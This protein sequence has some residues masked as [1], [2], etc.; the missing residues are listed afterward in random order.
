MVA[1]VSGSGLGLF[2]TTGSSGNPNVGRGGE[3]VSVNTATGNLIIQGVDETLGARGLDLALVRTY[4]SQ[5]LLN[6]DNGDNWRLGVN[7]RVFALTGTVN[8]AG[9]TITKVFGDAAQVVYTYDTTLG[10]YVSTD[11]DGA[12]DTL[13]FNATTSEWT[14]TDESS[15][16][17][18]TYDS[19]GRL[20]ASRDS[21]GNLVSYIYTG[22]LLTQIVDASGQQ[23]F[24]DYTGNNLTQVRVVSSGAT[25]TL[26]HYSYDGQNRLSTVTVDLSPGDNAIADGDVYVTTYTYEGTS[27]RVASVTQ[28]DGSSC[29]FT[30]QLIDGEYRVHTYTDGEGRVTTLEYSQPVGGG[31]STP[32]SA[33]ANSAVLS[34][35]ESSTSSTD[36][37]I[38]NGALVTNDTQ[39]T[40]DT[41]NLNAGALSTPAGGSVWSLPTGFDMPPDMQ[42]SDPKVAF[43]ANGNGFVVWSHIFADGSGELLVQRYTRATNSWGA[44]ETLVTNSELTD[45]PIPS[46]LAVDAAGNA[47]V[48]F[49]A[50]SNFGAGMVARRYDAASATWGMFGNLGGGSSLGTGYGV[51][52]VAINGAFAAVTYLT[53]GGGHANLVTSVLSGS[54][55]LLPVAMESSTTNVDN[56]SMAMD[57]QGNINVVF[58]QGTAVS[59]TRY[60]ASTATWSS[61]TTL[62]AVASARVQV[63]LDGA[64]NGFATWAQGADLMMSRYTRST[65]TWGAA[66]ALDSLSTTVGTQALAM[67]AAGNAVVSWTQSDG[68]AASVYARRYNAATSAWSAATALES[69]AGPAFNNLSVAINGNYAAVEWTLQHGVNYTAYGATFNGTAWSA[70]V[71]F[72]AAGPFG[73]LSI[74]VDSLGNS[75]AFWQVGDGSS[76]IYYSRF[77]NSLPA[78][79]AWN[80]ASLIEAEPSG[81]TATVPQVAYDSNGNGFAIWVVKRNSPAAVTIKAARY[82]RSTNTWAAP[83]TLYTAANA[84]VPSASLAVDAGGNAIVAWTVGG[85]MSAVR[86]TGTTWG[87]VLSAG[88]GSGAPIVAMNGNFAAIVWQDGSPLS[89]RAQWATR[90]NG[91]AWTAKVSLDLAGVPPFG[92]TVAVDNQGNI[93]V[94]FAQLNSG[95]SANGL[96]VVRYTASSNTWSAMLAIATANTSAPAPGNPQIAFDA[97]GNGVLAWSEGG[98]LRTARYTRSTNTWAAAV[99][100]DNLSG[101]VSSPSLSLDAAGN[102]LVAWIQVDETDGVASAYSKIYNAATATW[103]AVTLHETQSL[104]VTDSSLRTAINGSFASVGWLQTDGARD[105]LYTARYNGSAWSAAALAEANINTVATPSLALDSLGNANLFWQQSDGTTVS[106]YQS[107][108]NVGGVPSYTVPPGATWPSVAFDLYGVNSAAAGTALQT[109]MGNPAL[110]SGAQISG[111]PATL[112]VTTVLPVPPYFL[113]PGTPTTPTWRSIAAVVYGVD[114]PEAGAALQALMGSAYPT[115]SVGLHISNLPALLTVQTTTTTTVPAYYVVTSTDWADV[116]EAVYGTRDPAAVEALKLATGLT[117]L[118]VGQHLPVPLTLNYTVNG[119]SG[120]TSSIYLRTDIEDPLGFVATQERDAAGRLTRVQSATVGD[121]RPETTFA[122]NADGNVTSITENPAGLNRQTVMSYDVHGN[123]LS[124]RDATG[125]TI[126]RTYSTR[127]QLLTESRYL[128]AD[129]DGAGTGVATAPITSRF[130]YDAEDHLRFTVSASGRVVE[131]RYNAAGERTTSLQYGGGL[132]ALAGLASDAALTEAQLVSWAQGQNLTTLQR[133]DFTYDFRGSLATTTAYTATDAAGAGAGTASVTRFVYDQRGRLLSSIDARGELTAGIADDYLTSYTYDGLGR[134]LAVTEWVSGATQVTT[135]SSYDDANRRDTITLAN[136]LVTTSVYNSAGE[137]TS[138]ILGASGVL[139]TTNYRYDADGRLRM[140]TD[141]LG[142]RTFSFYDE[143][144]R[145]VAM[146]DAAGSLTE[147]IYDDVSALV[148]SVQYAVQLDAATLASLVDGGVPQDV[149]LADLRDAADGVP[150]S[151]RITRSV[152]DVAGRLAFGID[153]DGAVTRYFYDGAGRRTTEVRFANRVAID[154]AVESLSVDFVEP[155]IVGSPED[156]RTRHFYDAD[157]N[158]IAT[159][160]SAGYLSEYL[161]DPAGFLVQQVGYATRTAAQYWVAGTLEELRPAQSVDDIR[162]RLF[163]DAQGRQV[164]ALDSQGYLS[165]SVYDVAGNMVATTRYDVV[166]PYTEGTSTFASLRAT[167]LAAPGA[168]ARTLTNA[169]DGR[170]RITTSTDFEGVVSTFAYDAV[171]NLLRSTRAVATTEAR[172]AEMRYD[173]LGR[174]VQQL[175]A[176]GSALITSGMSQAA[177]DDIWSRYGVSVAYDAAGRRISTTVRPNDAQTNTTLYF[178]DADGRQRFEVNAPGEV[179]ETRYD[180][181][182]QATESLAYVN[183]ISTASLAG[184]AIVQ[185]L[186]DRVAAAADAARDSHSL[187]AYTR[188]GQVLSTATSE[189]ANTAYEYDAFGDNTARTSRVNDGFFRNIMSQP[190]PRSLRYDYTYDTR[191]QLTRTAYDVDGMELEW[192]TGFDPFHTVIEETV[193]DAFGRIVSQTDGRGSVTQHSYDRLGREVTTTDAF[194]NAG[195]TSYDAFSR[196]LTM[197]DRLGNQTTYAYDDAARSMSMTTPEGI[198][199]VTTHNRHGQTL[200][201]TAAGKTT[202]YSYDLNGALLESFDNLGSLGE[203]SYDRAGR[204]ITT[205]TALGTTTTFGYDAADRVLTRQVDSPLD[206][207]SLVSQYVYDGQGRITR[208]TEPGGRVTATTYDRDSRVVQVAVDPDGLNLRTTYSYDRAGNVIDVVEGA[209]SAL[210]RHVSYEYD[211]LGRRVT[212]RIDPAINS[213]DNLN[214]RT[215]YRYDETGNLIRKSNSIG[216]TWFAYDAGSRLRF[217]IDELGGVSENVFD[218]VGRVTATRRYANAIDTNAVATG[219][220]FAL[221]LEGVAAAL[222]PSGQDRI[223]QS[224]FDGDGREV[225]TINGL[226]GVTERTFD[227]N[228]NVTRTRLYAKAI[229]TATYHSLTE[230]RAALTLAGNDIVNVAAADRVSFAA[231][232]LRGRATFA[233]NGLGAVTRSEYDVRGNVVSSTAYATPR[234]VSLPN[235]PAALQSWAAGTAVANDPHNRSTRYWYDGLDRLRFTLDAEGYLTETRFDDIGRTEESVSYAGAP[236]AIGAAADLDDVETIAVGLRNV[237]A[238]HYSRSVR[239][240]AGRVT[241]VYDAANNY[242]EYVYDAL[243][244]RT[245]L[246]NKLGAVWTYEYDANRRMIAE[247]TPL[248]E[249]TRTSVTDPWAVMG[250]PLATTVG[251]RSVI[252]RFEY[253]ELGNLTLRIEDADQPGARYTQYWYDR[254]GRQERVVIFVP[255]YDAEGESI[256]DWYGE[257]EARPRIEFDFSQTT[258]TNYDTLGDAVFN[259]DAAGSVTQNIYDRLGRLRYAVDAENGVTEYRYD[260]FGNQTELVRYAESVYLDTEIA[261]QFTIDNIASFITPDATRDRVITTEYDRVNRAVRVIEPATFVFDPSAGTPGGQYYTAS[262]TTTNQYDAFGRL[263]KQSKLVNPALG[264]WADTYSYYDERGMCIASIDALGYLTTMEYDAFGNALRTVEYAKALAA[265]TWNTSTH[266]SA[267]VT[268][269]AS[270]PH[271]SAGYDRITEWTYDSRNRRVSERHRGIEYSAATSSGITE[272]VTDLLM[273]FGFDALG[274]QTRVTDGNGAATYTYYDVLGRQIAIAAPSRDA[275][276]GTILT[277][278]VGMKRDAFGNMVEQRVYANGASAAS[279]AAFTASTSASDRVSRTLYD[280]RNL[281]IQN[282]DAEGN[283]SLVSYNARGDIGREWQATGAFPHNEIGSA[284]VRITAYTYDRLGRQT[285]AVT[286]LEADRDSGAANYRYDEISTSN[287]YNNFGEIEYRSGAGRQET[288]EYD[289]SGRVVRSNSGD[290]VTKVYLYD[291][292]GH[293]TAEI[294]SSTRDL[295]QLDIAAVAALT[296]GRMRTET[297]YDI[298]GRVVEQRQ[299]NFAVANPNVGLQAIGGLLRVDANVMAPNNPDAVFRVVTETVDYGDGDFNDYETSQIDPGASLADGGGYMYTAPTAEN[300]GGGWVQDPNYALVSKRYI[301][302]VR[303]PGLGYDNGQRALASFEFRPSS[304]GAYTPLRVVNLPNNEIGV[305]ISALANGSYEYRLTYTMPNATEPYAIATG[306]LGVGGVLSLADTTAA[307]LAGENLSATSV[308]TEVALNIPFRDANFRI[309]DF[310]GIAALDSLVYRR[311]DNDGVFEYV[312]DRAAEVED[313]GGYYRTATGFVQ[314]PDYLPSHSRLVQWNAAADPDLTPVFEFSRVGSGSW[315][316]LAVESLVGGVYSVAIGDYADGDYEFRVS[317]MSIADPSAA[318]LATATGAIR[319]E[320]AQVTDSVQLVNDRPDDAGTVAPLAIRPAGSTNVTS[321]VVTSAEFDEASATGVSFVGTNDV[322]VTFASITGPV[323]IELEY[324]TVAV[325]ALLDPGPA[326]EGW[327]SE[328]RRISLLVA[329]GSTAASGLHLTWSDVFGESSSGGISE[330]LAVRV[331]AVSGSDATLRYSTNAVDLVDQGGSTLAWKA[332]WNPAVTATFNVRRVGSDEWQSIDVTRVAGDFVVDL[333]NLAPGQWEYQAAQLQDGDVRAIASGVLTTHGSSVLN[334]QEPPPGGV[335]PIEAV[336]PVTGYSSGAVGITLTS[337]ASHAIAGPAV[338]GQP[339]PLQWNG[340]NQ[341]DLTWADLGTGDVRVVIDYTSADR[342]SYNHVSGGSGWETTAA[343][344]PGTRASREQV[345]TTGATGAAFTWTDSNT[346]LVGGITELQRVRV[347]TLVSGSWVLRLDHDPSAVRSGQSIYWGKADDP[348]VTSEFRVRAVG[349]TTWA[350][351]AITTNG[352][353][354]DIV[355]VDNLAAGN[356]EYQILRSRAGNVVIALTSG[357]FTI[358]GNREAGDLA[359]T[360]H[361]VTFDQGASDFGPVTWNGNDLAWSQAPVAGDTITLR[362]RE[363]GSSTWN[364]Q[365]ISGSGPDFSA[366]VGATGAT[367]VEYEVLYTHSGQSTPYSRAGGRLNA[368][369]ATNYTP[370]TYTFT[371]TSDYDSVMA[372]VEGILAYDG[373]ISFTTLIL[374]TDVEFRVRQG[375]GEW[376][377]LNAEYLGDGYSVDLHSLL[378][379]EYSYEI[380]YIHWS[381]SVPHAYASGTVTIGGDAQG[382]GMSLLDTT[383]YM[384]TIFTDSSPG[385]P[386]RVQTFDRWG[387]VVSA[388]DASGNTTNYRYNHTNTLLETILP[389]VQVVDIA[390]GT[391]ETHLERPVQENHYDLLGRL[392]ATRDANGNVSRA[393]YNVAGDLLR[394]VAADGGVKSRVYNAFGDVVLS[395]DQLG[396]RTRLAYDRLSQLTS[397]EREVVLGGLGSGNTAQ[398]LIDTYA[399]DDLGE[400][401]RETNAAGESTEYEYF[402]DGRLRSRTTNRGFTTSYGYDAN[403]NKTF[404]RDANGSTQRWDY[405]GFNRMT[406]SEDM[407][408]TRT[409]YRYDL[410]GQLTYQ[411]SSLGQRQAYFYDEAGHLTRIVDTGSPSKTLAPVVGVN[412]ISE[413]GYDIEGRRV[414]ERTVI[415][416]RVHQDNFTSFDAL[417]RMSRAADPDYE[418]TYSYDA[419]GNRTRINADYYN[420]IG[421]GAGYVQTQDLWYTYD[422]MN[423]VLTSQ[424]TNFAGT[425]SI[426]GSQGIDLTYNLKGER[427]SARTN[428]EHYG[429]SLSVLNGNVVSATYNR[430]KFGLFTERYTY[431]GVGRLLATD[432]DAPSTTHNLGTGAVTTGVTPLRTAT[433]QFDAASREILSVTYSMDPDEDTDTSLDTWTTNTTYDGDGR[434]AQQVTRLN[435]IMN[436]RVTFGD[437]TFYRS[438]TFTVTNSFFRAVVAR[439]SGTTGVSSRTSH[440]LPSFSSSVRTVQNVWDGQGWDSAGNLMGYRVEFFKETNGKL[441]YYTDHTFDYRLAQTYQLINEKTNSEGKG[442]PGKGSTTRTYNVNGELVQYSDNKDQKKNRYFAND[443]QGQAL[444]VVNGKF[445]GRSGRLSA[446]RAFDNALTRT[447][448]KV[449][450]QYFFFANGQNIGTFG[451]LVDSEGTIKANFD[452]NYTPVSGGYPSA[453]PSEVVAHS[454]DTLRT[455]AARV[456]GDSNLWYVLAEANGLTN[457]D[458]K[459]EA[460]VQ[461]QVPNKVL[462]LSNNAESFKPY[463]ASLALGDTTPTQ[464]PPGGGCGVIGMIIM[465]VVMIVATIFTAG[466]AAVGF[467]A[468]FGQIMAAGASVMLGGTAVAGVAVAASQ[469]TLGFAGTA[470]VAAGVGSAVSQGVGI[471]IGAQQKFDWKQVGISAISA[472]VTAGFGATLNAGGKLANAVNVV[473]AGGKISAGTRVLAAAG[474]FLANPVGNAIGSSMLTQGLSVATG[475]QSSFNWREVAVAAASSIGSMGASKAGG[476]VTGTSGNAVRGFLGKVTTNAI[477]K[478]IQMAFAGK[479]EVGAVLADAFGNAVGD[480]IVE[481]LQ[482]GATPSP[483]KPAVVNDPDFVEITVQKNVANADQN[484]DMA[485]VATSDMPTGDE[486]REIKKDQGG[487]ASSVSAPSTTD[488]A[489]Y[490][491][492]TFD[493]QRQKYV[494]YGSDGSMWVHDG[495]AWTLEPPISGEIVVTA[496]REDPQLHKSDGPVAR[497]TTMMPTKLEWVH[498]ASDVRD[499]WNSNLESLDVGNDESKFLTGR[500]GAHDGFVSVYGGSTSTLDGVPDVYGGTYYLEKDGYQRPILGDAGP[501]AFKQQQHLIERVAEAYDKIPLEFRPGY[502]DLG[503]ELQVASLLFGGGEVIATARGLEGLASM[504]GVASLVTGTGARVA[505]KEY[506]ETLKFLSEKAADHKIEESMKGFGFGKAV[507]IYKYVD[508]LDEVNEALAKLPTGR[509]I[510]NAPPPN[511]LMQL[512]DEQYAERFGLNLM[513]I[514]SARGPTPP[515]PPASPN[516]IKKKG[517]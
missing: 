166:V 340:T 11:G 49:R 250:A 153:A 397:M 266:G 417:G 33:N 144:G 433:R 178:Y 453:T 509:T 12:H 237:S 31:G 19:Q 505:D 69:S 121:V 304:G 175:S 35:T 393:E 273:T 85:Q 446:T 371:Q 83:T 499:F 188:R 220:F 99:N 80:L 260:T 350:T 344:V 38:V 414:A 377:T 482:E 88:V 466:A 317:Y 245:S 132:Y 354:L 454:G 232:D 52:A 161:R 385:T 114:S 174:V 441:K 366:V 8:T 303:P 508:F 422:N 473:E 47:L 319:L 384:R 61:P 495:T 136:G 67:D 489:R 23:T 364:E 110:N 159:L 242:E 405:D 360:Q 440:V 272:S 409:D 249:V 292:A 339:P 327:A 238:D 302:W 359:L 213:V 471:A 284:P 122:Y 392:V 108:F 125:N 349:A 7:R 318:A 370:A 66:T 330:I 43:D 278:L 346:S 75:L 141:P 207:Q 432:Q 423:R 426:T 514:K 225:F 279:E 449:K 399:Y 335:Y 21:D 428:G 173:E 148:K 334:A 447:G 4:N 116:T 263:L 394:E 146:V 283:H 331:Y 436:T 315:N 375:S 517:P 347:Y 155:L 53:D 118:T 22:A 387:N 357:T 310:A 138:T 87:S 102:A 128:V 427:T 342:Y 91:T 150:A 183:R 5:G 391:V 34:T 289:Q 126:T 421:R 269:A 503:K 358:S 429:M 512:T 470:A 195:T 287:Y 494:Q 219:L 255:V 111:W 515:P 322:L 156:R 293:A 280:A 410:N 365:T 112:S 257:L 468:G 224:V 472:G 404:E 262:P 182:G 413:Y 313:G 333:A 209:G 234:D 147:F 455:L 308:A 27:H 297:R 407:G 306:T 191:G 481:K 443:A 218:A 201:I 491:K 152:Y 154:A 96:Y 184:G 134:V 270:S 291:L 456:F 129:P 3:R 502:G 203:T 115:L 46:A 484:P 383:E 398:A 28:T 362:T 296:T 474:K 143:A 124:S 217:T 265:G 84:T 353:G 73:G 130:V 504:L 321:S 6:D 76:D 320:P 307:T 50:A 513:A 425:I 298:A 261:D 336:A 378:N 381:S 229:A 135:L 415:D 231:F 332:P 14:W 380:R 25:Q 197:R 205:T 44:I 51:P 119:G 406:F 467:A 90:W 226:G 164:G 301:H 486:M 2:G 145:R 458:E 275:G 120:G 341:V 309:G 442:E 401:T 185:T 196:V 212:E 107:R 133:V 113:V 9:S 254:V 479:I 221:S 259:T 86:Y 18:E 189:G 355:D 469:L 17:T 167:A 487:G 363:A 246:R 187:I 30:Y 286:P 240:V 337:S 60:T 48:A 206:G 55:W 475:L 326:G 438:E 277:P 105:N 345:F 177:I 400:R 176:Q 511:P 395:T 77:S 101:A 492:T 94:S 16:N 192:A 258:E 411:T 376:Q 299:P 477:N 276:N 32:V 211:V 356:Y 171:G 98:N 324:R 106:V 59:R 214:Y 193:Y 81:T 488:V 388:T 311:V 140:V 408:A 253:N 480:S 215:D 464:P 216:M 343:F 58:V 208:V 200:R 244:N 312:V 285:S 198:V 403:G 93:A 267:P 416:G 127:N 248:V 338:N 204:Q 439:L 57:G 412:R 420:H 368:S 497:R 465:I 282:T 288:F 168:V 64:G 351:R 431:D 483:V 13:A 165:E 247:H 373:Q 437:A 233:V 139:G 97:N 10:R 256:F 190:G 123:L 485:T 223:T 92:Q 72:G 56:F 179:R 450:A 435:G 251:V 37:G 79:G 222:V 29:A 82:T 180:A 1:V 461:L 162:S 71:Q 42:A 386:T 328:T 295:S 463:D 290:G 36:H 452:V 170:G 389:Q 41:Y 281:A 490:S 169:Y 239:D 367:I 498:R 374:G 264:L 501:E 131:H 241:R 109:A 379:G 294:R 172:S 361:N 202:Q 70:A 210:P 506:A 89:N 402:V 451:Q 24:L 419:V 507:A 445:D 430:I 78:G 372:P 142:A 199:V 137:L 510:A 186:L 68:V 459:I 329:N 325:D 314:K 236:A 45:G 15:R 382:S 40:V 476:W 149:D 434:T 103:G 496:V 462:S 271:D 104:A 305:D 151:D 396:Y 323:R 268:T 274:N 194:G 352:A 348:A 252:N 158:E 62:A 448:N 160:D 117:T 230:V 100:L 444:T 54:T 235:T 316:Q 157:G 95:A 74:A 500:P 516:Y 163:H 424:G 418:V 460:G 26:T 63:A 243:G 181:F 390:G 39:T 227:D 20:S 457:P 228:G 65:N 478:S 493:R 300:P 369:V